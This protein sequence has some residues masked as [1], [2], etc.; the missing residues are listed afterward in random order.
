MFCAKIADY[1][2]LDFG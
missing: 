2:I 1:Y